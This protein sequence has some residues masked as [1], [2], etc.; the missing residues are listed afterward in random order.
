M[1]LQHDDLAAVDRFAE[2]VDVALE[3]G[4]AGTQESALRLIAT[5]VAAGIALTIAVRGSG[6]VSTVFY[7][8]GLALLVFAVARLLPQLAPN[9]RA[10]R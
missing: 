6:A 8:V 1:T 7:V 2:S 9:G 10:G 4:A 5:W 3:E